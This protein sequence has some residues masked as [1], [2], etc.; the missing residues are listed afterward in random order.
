[1][2]KLKINRIWAKVRGLFQRRF[3][4]ALPAKLCNMP[5]PRNCF[6]SSQ[7]TFGLKRLKSA[8]ITDL[9]LNFATLEKYKKSHD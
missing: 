4:K 8:M 9:I 2:K 5:P 1:M 3:T 6:V 7:G